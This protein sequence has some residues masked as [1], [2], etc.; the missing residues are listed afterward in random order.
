MTEPLNWRTALQDWLTTHPKTMPDKVRQLREEFIRLFPKER[1]GE[2]TLERY[3]VG[4]EG[5]RQS[6]WYW[7]E[8]K[9]YDLGSISGGS[10][11]KTGVWWDGKTREWKWLKWYEAQSA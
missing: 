11:H 6:F 7:L 8:W 5:F 3:A 9:T 2:M 1:L 4:H 10:V